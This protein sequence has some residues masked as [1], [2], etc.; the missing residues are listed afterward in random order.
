MFRSA[1]SGLSAAALSASL[2]STLA[3][4]SFASLVTFALPAQAATP[5]ALPSLESFSKAGE[6]VAL[7]KQYPTLVGKTLQVGL[8]GYTVGFE[9]PAKDDPSKI[10]G[11]DPDLIAYM[12]ACLG[13]KH[14]FQNVAFNVLVSGIAGGRFDMGPNLYVT[15]VRR[16]QVAFVSS[17]SVID[18]SVIKKGNPKHLTS[19][20]S[21]C[22][23]TV[24][25]AAGTY[26][27]VSLV[28]P[29][30]EKCKAAGKPE[31]NLLLLQATDASVQAVQSGRA[32]I[33][34]TAESDAKALAS[35]VPDLQSGFTID[36]PILNG[37]PT[38][39][40]N[41]VMRGAVLASMKV[42]QSHGI[43]KTLLDKWGQ[44]A[45]SERPAADAE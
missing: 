33:Y 26:E 36:L 7:R 39:K 35:S 9:A 42:I 6:C 17:F 32:D 4:A 16:K 38:A 29:L 40:D 15:D 30:V 41:K 3:L 5:N 23:A 12:G 1:F 37:F 34:L 45:K 31:V 44:D 27:A 28:P 43:E 14:E 22:G 13:F 24:A 10:E 25:A 2:T 21:L 11:L 18:G 20:D 8:G 19:L